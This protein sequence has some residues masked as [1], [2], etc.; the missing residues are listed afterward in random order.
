MTDRLAALDAMRAELLATERARGPEEPPPE[1]NDGYVRLLFAC[2]YAGLGAA[3]AGELEA[4]GR[5]LLARHLGDPVHAWLVAAFAE[6]IRGEPLSDTLREQLDR[7]ERIDR[8]KVD[9][10]R[11]ASR[12]LACEPVDAIYRFGGGR[13]WTEADTA[14]MIERAL[15]A[16]DEA[17]EPDEADAA[18]ECALG[19][20]VAKDLDRSFSAG[21][22]AQLLPRSSA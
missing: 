1:V 17:V 15:A 10:V 6:R 4:E 2:G 7:L 22:L 13:R 9:R 21:A 19:G 20:I 3:T 5:A 14:R 12:L 18:I 16:A 8:Y 11:E